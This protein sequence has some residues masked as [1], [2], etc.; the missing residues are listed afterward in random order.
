MHRLLI[1]FGCIIIGLIPASGSA[2][3]TAPQ[4]VAGDLRSPI[5]TGYLFDGANFIP[6]P[7]VV[8]E[9]D[10]R[11]LVNEL[12][13][14]ESNVQEPGQRKPVVEVETDPG[15]PPLGMSPVQD[16]KEAYEYWLKKVIYLHR[17]HDFATVQRLFIQAVEES[18]SGVTAR[19]DD[20]LPDGVLLTSADGEEYYPLRLGKSFAADPDPVATARRAKEA[21]ARSLRNALIKGL[22]VWVVNRQGGMVLTAPGKTA[23]FVRIMSETVGGQE[24][25]AKLKI[26]NIVKYYDDVWSKM[27]VEFTDAEKLRAYCA[28]PPAAAAPPITRPAEQIPPPVV[29]IKPQ[30]TTAAEQREKSQSATITNIV[31]AIIAIVVFLLVAVYLFRQR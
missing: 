7:Y 16:S 25:L 15:P 2:A 1:L 3:E 4:A 29:E 20:S 14:F 26:L 23:D 19:L 28:A 10:Q 22:A 5:A 21:Q 6:G 12:V 9:S 8:T 27:V 18:R 17:H 11:V 24:R 30:P 31:V 13:V